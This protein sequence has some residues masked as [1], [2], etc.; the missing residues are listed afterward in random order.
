MDLFKPSGIDIQA[1]LNPDSTALTTLQNQP[2]TV[3]INPNDYNVFGTADRTGNNLELST[4]NTLY[5]DMQ[6]ASTDFEGSLVSKTPKLADIYKTGEVPAIELGGGVFGVPVRDSNVGKTYAVV[7]QNKVANKVM[8]MGDDFLDENSLRALTGGSTTPFKIT[9]PKTYQVNRNGTNYTITNNP[10]IDLEEALKDTKKMIQSAKGEKT[11]LD[12]KLKV[13]TNPKEVNKLIQE[14]DAIDKQ[15]E[16]LKKQSLFQSPDTNK[17][18]REITDKL[19]ELELQYRQFGHM[20]PKKDRVALRKEIQNQRRD[21]RLLQNRVLKNQTLKLPNI[22]SEKEANNFLWEELRGAKKLTLSPAVLQYLDCKVAHTDMTEGVDKVKRVIDLNNTIDFKQEDADIYGDDPEDDVADDNSMRTNS[23][24]YDKSEEALKYLIESKQPIDF[25]VTKNSMVHEY[26]VDGKKQI[27]AIPIDAKTIVSQSNLGGTGLG[28]TLVNFNPS[29]YDASL[30]RGL[31]GGRELDSILGC[32]KDPIY[33]KTIKYIIDHPND[34]KNIQKLG[35]YHSVNENNKPTFLW[36]LNDKDNRKIIN[37]YYSQLAKLGDYSDAPEKTNVLEMTPK[38]QEA[39]DLT[40][41]MRYELHKNI[42]SKNRE[43]T[44]WGKEYNN[45]R[46]QAIYENNIKNLKQN[47]IESI[48][49][50]LEAVENDLPYSELTN[51]AKQMFK[52]PMEYETIRKDGNALAEF[53]GI[54]EEIQNYRV[55]GLYRSQRARAEQIRELLKIEPMISKQ[56]LNKKER[57]ANKLQDKEIRGKIEEYQGKIKDLGKKIQEE[58]GRN[59]ETKDVVK[60]VKRGL[61]EKI[62][63]NPG[64][65]DV[66]ADRVLEKFNEVIDGRS[67]GGEDLTDTTDYTRDQAEQMPTKQYFDGLTRANSEVTVKL[68]TLGE[69]RKL[70]EEWVTPI[71]KQF[72]MIF[73]I[74]TRDEQLYFINI[75][76]N[77][78]PAFQRTF[79]MPVFNHYL[80]DRTEAGYKRIPTRTKFLAPNTVILSKDKNTGQIIRV[81]YVSYNKNIDA[82]YMA[83]VRPTDYAAVMNKWLP[84]KQ[85]K[86]MS[87]MEIRPDGRPIPRAGNVKFWGIEQKN[88]LKPAWDENQLT[89]IPQITKNDNINEKPIN[90]WDNRFDNTHGKFIG[91]GFRNDNRRTKKANFNKQNNNTPQQQGNDRMISRD[92]MKLMIALGISGASF[93]TIAKLMEKRREELKQQ[94]M[95]DFMI[96]NTLKKEFKNGQLGSN[97]PKINRMGSQFLLNR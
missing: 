50:V 78:L 68:K 49:E 58:R 28:R 97:V 29:N 4:V 14:K 33:L 61:A 45:K 56:K 26:F 30:T 22:E 87:V 13:V 91:E 19:N 60:F 35:V 80:F 71:M 55:A 79:R 96:N 37:K 44:K 59:P 15:L 5:Q 64:F 85:Y 10:N 36:F 40:M 12:N 69:N 21:A 81:F 42:S 73:K 57:K 20:L 93:Y 75:R 76:P 43:L 27:L 8:K 25:Y 48:Q 53:F 31:V 83:E 66:P 70:A 38:E 84:K 1:A 72:R 23:S 67:V 9:V 41:K 34:P 3:M 51:N 16:D 89:A 92:V 7:T 74:N 17:A 2:N 54:K 46:L 6:N 32:L 95:N 52:N 86:G 39:A 77:N 47:D 88:E 94:G 65:E 24:I 63:E 82:I 90:R 18:I 11:R 62:K